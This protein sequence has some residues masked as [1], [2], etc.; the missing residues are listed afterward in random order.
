VDYGSVELLGLTIEEAQKAIRDY[1]MKSA[2]K[3][4]RVQVS[5]AQSRGMQQLQGDH[6]VRMDGTI[7]LG[8]YGSVTVAG[9][10]LDQARKAIE[11]HLS[12]Y[13]LNPEISLDV[14]AYNSK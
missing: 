14:Y 11:E 5:P 6:L 13:L 4:P 7:G 10:T 12:Q 2:L 8:L 9:M 3:N 1:L